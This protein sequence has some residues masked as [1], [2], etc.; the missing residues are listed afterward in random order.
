MLLTRPAGIIVLLL[1][2]N[3]P[4]TELGVWGGAGK[5]A[6]DGGRPPP[7]TVP[8]FRCWAAEERRVQAALL[9]NFS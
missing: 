8:E 6:R 3:P 2:T 4:P 5:A 1:D 7:P 9:L